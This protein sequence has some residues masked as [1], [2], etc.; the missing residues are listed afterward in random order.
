MAKPIPKIKAL[1]LLKDAWPQ[2]NYQRLVSTYFDTPDRYLW[3]HGVSLRVRQNEQGLVQTLKQQ[4]SSA[5]DR[6]EWEV[7]VNQNLPD[8]DAL[9]NTPLASFF[10][11]RRVGERLQA[12]FAVDVERLSITLAIGK[13]RLEAAVDQGSVKAEG[14]SIPVNEL[15]LELK[16]GEKPALFEL[17][18][19]FCRNAPLRLSF[20]S[21]AERGYLL[22]EGAWGQSLKA[23]QPQLA[24]DMNCRE[25][26]EAIC[27]CCMHDFMVNTH[28]LETS[29]RVEA[30]HRGRIAIRRLRA[31]LQLFRPVASDDA[32][33]GLVDELK[34]ISDLFGEARD[35]DVF[36]EERRKS[37]GIWLSS[38]APC[39]K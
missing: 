14:R 29:D 7:K 9:K 10:K 38:S 20:I 39:Q 28:A 21:K 18:R 32:Y 15:E 13:S 6:G 8:I 27:R 25:A 36:Q 35:L 17:A 30:V 19:A 4:K 2:A 24:A 11:K 5:L 37:C 22:A 23:T 33:Q 31:G 3:K 34:W 26:F 16:E 1:P 12:N